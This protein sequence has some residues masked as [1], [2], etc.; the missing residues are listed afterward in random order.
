MRVMAAT[1][2]LRSILSPAEMTALPTEDPNP[3]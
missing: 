1:G 3:L 2:T